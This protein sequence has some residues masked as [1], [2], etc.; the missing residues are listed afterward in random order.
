M[1][2]EPQPMTPISQDDCARLLIRASRIETILD[3]DIEFLEAATNAGE[4]GELYQL[5]EDVRDLLDR[6]ERL[7]AENV[8]LK[9]KL[10]ALE[11]RE[12]YLD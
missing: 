10:K 12:A 2:P 3:E 8:A 11:E 9:A 6:V 5:C 7:E 1:N 4:A